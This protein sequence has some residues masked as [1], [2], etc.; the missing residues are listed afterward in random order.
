MILWRPRM[1]IV[2]QSIESRRIL[3]KKYFKTFLIWVISLILPCLNGILNN[4]FTELVYRSYFKRDG[5][6]K[7]SKSEIKKF[8]AKEKNW[9]REKKKQGSKAV[10]IYYLLNYNVYIPLL[11][12]CLK[13]LWIS[14]FF[15]LACGN[16]CHTLNFRI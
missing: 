5:K 9:A 3:N 2:A 13:Y 11:R 1:E 15:V 6:N 8:W 10:K 4:L 14:V 7:I 16:P 12:F